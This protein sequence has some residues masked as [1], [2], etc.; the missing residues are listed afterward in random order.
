MTQISTN[1]R[2]RELALNAPF[3]QQI[4]MEII[5][6]GSGWGGF[7][8]YAATLTGCK[9][10][11]V[12]ISQEQFN[13][14]QLR[15]EREGLQDLVTVKLQDYRDVEGQFDKLVS[16]EMIEAIGHQYLDTYFRK[17][18]AL[19]KPSGKALIQAIVIDDNRLL[20]HC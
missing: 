16:I 10:T 7:A 18:N 8:C 13:E 12:T 11:T 15:I 9:V 20:A 1:S 19:L 17:L 14:T 5:E 3:I 2:I 4:G 6:I